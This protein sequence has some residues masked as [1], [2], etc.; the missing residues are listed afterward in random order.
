MMHVNHSSTRGI[1]I[2]VFLAMSKYTEQNYYNVD[3]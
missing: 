2:V 3:E 1:A